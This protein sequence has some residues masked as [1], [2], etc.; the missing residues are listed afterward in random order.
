MTLLRKCYVNENPRLPIEFTETN[1]HGGLI[2][3]RRACPVRDDESRQ[4]R[5]VTGSA[6]I[7]AVEAITRALPLLRSESSPQQS[8]QT[9]DFLESLLFHLHLQW[10]VGTAAKQAKKLD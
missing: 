9:A 7:T 6:K 2:A 8:G 10:S 3:L 4:G 1:A 5:G